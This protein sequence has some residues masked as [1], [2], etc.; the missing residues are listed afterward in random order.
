MQLLFLLWILPAVTCS[1]G[2]L[3]SSFSSSSSSLETKMTTSSSSLLDDHLLVIPPP[4]SPDCWLD[5]IRDLGIAHL[6]GAACT[7]LDAPHQQ[8]LSLQLTRCHLQTMGRPLMMDLTTTEEENHDD[9]VCWNIR[10]DTVAECLPRLSDVAATTYTLFF[11]DIHH[12]CTRLLQETISK[13]YYQTS[14]E[15]AQISKLAESR[16]SQMVEQQDQAMVVWEERE[17]SMTRWLETHARQTTSQTLQLQEELQL[18]QQRQLQEHKQELQ[19]L[20]DTVQKT[21]LSI[22]PWTQTVDFVL[23]HATT[24]Y[25]IIKVLMVSFGL[26]LVILLVTAPK[27]LKWM[28]FRLFMTVLVAGGA[29]IALH[30]WLTEDEELSPL[31][32]RELSNDLQVFFHSALCAAYLEGIVSSICCRRKHK[33]DYEEEKEDYD[34]RIRWKRQEELLRRLERCNQQNQQIMFQQQQQ[35]PIP[36]AHIFSPYPKPLFHPQTA[37]LPTTTQPK[38]AAAATSPPPFVS[39]APHHLVPSS[40]MPWNNMNPSW[41]YP[42]IPV[43]SVT[44][45]PPAKAK[46]IMDTPLPKDSTNDPTSKVGTKKRTVADVIEQVQEG[47]G[48]EPLSKRQRTV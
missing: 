35:Q 1:H 20:A 6:D 10:A 30:L 22:T 23:A 11:K 25:S 32:K 29:E 33:D 40:T 48:M 13:Q 5:T 41:V 28:R 37:A 27:Q 24:G 34:D 36:A 43:V 21:R 46:D 4:E 8:A 44:P 15:L 47:D 14:Q 18:L 19:S 16:L 38:H 26:G 2:G 9:N 42:G 3:F 31:E 45:S 7:F 17:E 12:L 39:P